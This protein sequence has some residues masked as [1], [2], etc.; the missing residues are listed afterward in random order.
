LERF[1]Y[2]QNYGILECD[3]FAMLRNTI[4]GKRRFYF[5]EAERESHLKFDKVEKY[6]RLYESEK[7]MNWWWVRYAEGFPAILVLCWDR[8]RKQ[9]VQAA[10]KKGNTCGLDFVVL[11]LS[12]LTGS[13]GRI[14]G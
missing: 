9:E 1:D 8:K 14:S 7:Y 10:I 12:E 5:I 13:L 6:V 2:H 3:A 11:S 4:T